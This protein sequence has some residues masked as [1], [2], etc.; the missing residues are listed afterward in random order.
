MTCWMPSHGWRCLSLIV[1][2]QPCMSHVPLHAAT[3]MACFCT[4]ACLHRD[5]NGLTGD[6]ENAGLARWS[7]RRSSSWWRIAGT[8]SPTSGQPS[9]SLRSGCRRCLT[10]CRAT[11]RRSAPS[12]D[13]LE[14]LPK[15]GGPGT[16]TAP[17]Q[18]P[19]EMCALLGCCSSCTFSSAGR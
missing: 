17:V 12:C 15:T 4:P 7:Q 16:V 19:A 3:L 8:R 10:P 14:H 11:R 9:R 6:F 1:L 18:D 2:M 13:R 5:G